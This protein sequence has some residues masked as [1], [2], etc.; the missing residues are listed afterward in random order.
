MYMC[1]Y[2]Y[3]YTH[4]YVYV[5]MFVCMHVCVC[6]YIYIYD[7]CVYIYIYIWWLQAAVGPPPRRRSLITRSNNCQCG[8]NPLNVWTVNFVFNF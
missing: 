5:C 2:I 7:M 3:I 1:V 6:I 8:P 4:I